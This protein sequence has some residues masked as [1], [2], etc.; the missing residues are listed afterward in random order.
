MNDK[1]KRK[2]S[3]QVVVMHELTDL[4]VVDSI[5]ED[6]RSN[7]GLVVWSNTSTTWLPILVLPSPECTRHSAD[8]GLWRLVTTTEPFTE[9]TD[10][11]LTQWSVSYKRI[12]N[13]LMKT[14]KRSSSHHQLDLCENILKNLIA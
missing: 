6:H 7:D 2:K 12:E 11:H 3:S 10:F 1:N 4:S 14:T 9:L 5:E 13:A 8:H